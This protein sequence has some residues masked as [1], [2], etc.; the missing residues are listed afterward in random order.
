MELAPGLA[1]TPFIPRGQIVR[2]KSWEL[3]GHTIEGL[4]VF[5]QDDWEAVPP[6]VREQIIDLFVRRSAEEGLEH[7]QSML[8]E[9]REDT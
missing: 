6:D 3:L 8:T 4:V 9:E 7:L 5:N 1:V 2:L